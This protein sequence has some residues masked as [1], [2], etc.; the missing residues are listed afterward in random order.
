MV[1]RCGGFPPGDYLTGTIELKDT[2]FL[3]LAPGA[4]LYGSKDIKDCRTDGDYA[5][6]AFHPIRALQK[7]SNRRCQNPQFAQLESG[8]AFLR[9]NLDRWDTM[10][11]DLESLNSNGID[12]L[13][14]LQENWEN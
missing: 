4:T 1:Q 10:I 13:Y 6:L 3:E 8:Y 9:G 12:P 14:F 11:S 2:T 5:P 7:P